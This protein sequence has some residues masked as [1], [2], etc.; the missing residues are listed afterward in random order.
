MGGEGVGEE[1]RREE[2]TENLP[3]RWDVEPGG[4]NTEISDRVGV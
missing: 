3:E 1:E 4:D 2:G